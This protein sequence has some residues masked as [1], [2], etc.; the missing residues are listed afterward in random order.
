VTSIKA[1][2][3]GTPEGNEREADFERAGGVATSQGPEAASPWT[4]L[5]VQ[6]CP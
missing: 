1:E 3:E 5:Q 2:A 6:G 4:E